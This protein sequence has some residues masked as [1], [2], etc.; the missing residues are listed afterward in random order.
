ML[1]TSIKITNTL[2]AVWLFEYDHF[3]W[4]TSSYTYNE[5]RYNGRIIDFSGID[6]SICR[7]DDNTI[8]EKKISFSVP[9]ENN[10]ISASKGESVTVRLIINDVQFLSWNFKITSFTRYYNKANFD[11]SDFLSYLIEDVDYPN[12]DL[13]NPLDTS[14][15]THSGS[16]NVCIPEIYGNPYIP[17]RSILIDSYQRY[18][19]GV[20]DGST[21]TI[22]EMSTPIEWDVRSVYDSSNATF[23]QSIYTINGKSLVTVLPRVGLT[24]SDAFFQSSGSL[25]DAPFKFSKSTTSLITNPSD[26]LSSIFQNLGIPSSGID[27]TSFSYC[28]DIADTL[29]F[30]FNVGLYEKEEAKN[31]ICKILSSCNF[32]IN[33]Y[34]KIYLK[35]VGDTS[36]ATI[37]RNDMWDFSFSE[38][39]LKNINDAGIV[40]YYENVQAGDEKK[41]KQ[42]YVPI[43]GT[44][45]SNSSTD[46]FL[47]PYF[48]DTVLIQQLARVYF[49]RKYW[50]NGSISFSAKKRY[51]K[52]ECG[53]KITIQDDLYHN[54][55]YYISSKKIGSDLSLQ[56][57]CD[58][59]LDDLGQIVDYDPDPVTIVSDISDRIYYSAKAYN[60][61]NFVNAANCRIYGTTA[62]KI[63]GTLSWT[64]ASVY[65][66]DSKVGSARITFKPTQTTGALS[67]GLSQ[68]PTS[69]INYTGIDY[70]WMLKSDGTCEAFASGV[71][72]GSYGSYTTS[73]LFEI[74]YDGYRV[75]FYIDGNHK[76]TVSEL[77][78]TLRFYVDSSF[79]SIDSSINSIVFEEYSDVTRT[80]INNGVITSG[81]IGDKAIDDDPTLGIDFNNSNIIVG[82]DGELSLSGSLTVNSGGG[83]TVND[84]GGIIVNSGGDISLIS[85]DTD[86]YDL[87]TIY[88]KHGA[89][90]TDPIKF[91][92]YVSSGQKYLYI[93]TEND[94][95]KYLRIGSSGQRW[96]SVQINAQGFGTIITDTAYK[97]TSMA[98]SEDYFISEL[99][100]YY[101]SVEHRGYFNIV[102]APEGD[103]IY[104]SVYNTK[105]VVLNA[106]V[107][108]QHVPIMTSPGTTYDGLIPYNGHF[109]FYIDSA[110]NLPYIRFKDS[111]GTYITK[112]I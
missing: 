12:T 35:Y 32:T 51:L 44:T 104:T 24:L 5:Q 71:S 103:I 63:A 59:Y 38:N 111:T 70:C 82:G 66:I 13:I 57:S 11:C 85:S 110:T 67:I 15:T 52:Y 86:P 109:Y 78:S 21:Y 80:A 17:L 55:D 102:V 79:Y 4:A 18:I 28:A 69:G 91:E 92:A 30:S 53:D 42:I 96:K 73:S 33:V 94:I 105:M 19:L 2:S 77:S 9:D 48:A 100:E 88:F 106:P 37:D 7:P 26:I 62:T 6:E 107:V 39:I 56:F 49:R 41:Q 112:A 65:S 99:R 3:K 101:D 43:Q 25:L 22:D 75:S 87:S 36:V 23:T 47:I 68:N 8:P 64:N 95:S 50:N 108:C 58:F 14:S 46:V 1:S 34:D 60:S 20:N 72:L 61:I 93:Q 31:V 74:I 83:I 81:Y 90:D 89:S 98:L 16:E 27:S 84:G 76:Y 54:G 97:T 29:G 45:Y 40:G 10:L